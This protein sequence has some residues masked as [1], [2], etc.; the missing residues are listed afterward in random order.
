MVWPT[1]GSRTAKEQNWSKAR[2]VM[3]GVYTNSYTGNSLE[4]YTK[5]CAVEVAILI[6][7]DG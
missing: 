5:H 7:G 4:T 6:D 3:T 2:P 1:L